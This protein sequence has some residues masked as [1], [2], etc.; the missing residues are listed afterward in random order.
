MA[1]QVRVS[2]LFGLEYSKTVWS[3]CRWDENANP[4]VSGKNYVVYICVCVGCD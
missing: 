2:V 4:N 3:F 1:M